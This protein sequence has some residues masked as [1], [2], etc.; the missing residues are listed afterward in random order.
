MSVRTDLALE[1]KELNPDCENG[2]ESQ[3]EV[4]GDIK[5]TRIKIKNSVGEKAI[6][7]P[8]GTYV[9]VEMPPLTDNGELNEVIVDSISGELQKFL[10]QS[11]LVLVAGLGNT[12]ITPDAIGPKTANG[13]LATRHI[14]GEIA[15]SIGLDDMRPVAV[16]AP[17]VLGQT[18]IETG[19]IIA[20]I[21]ELI[22]PTAVIVIDALAS[23][24]LSR[25]GCTVQMSD[26]GICPGSGVGNK[27]AE[28]SKRTVGVPVIAVGV[29]TVV[30]A[31][32]LAQDLTGHECNDTVNP[33]GAKMIVT[34]QE[35][36]LLISRGAET[37][38]RAVNYALQKDV[39]RETLL[40]LI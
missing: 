37:L 35:I 29:P 2:V 13:I 40:M 10:P 3:E 22:K 30:D 21:A 5:I 11:G 39:D 1:E 6:G 31:V 17:G 33:R 4:N 28:I 19:E 12:S 18:G 14:E 15:R 26:A 9:T 24:C 38:S 36:D 27:R 32:T 7:K 8:I 25:L 16:I 34:P 23:R 20:G